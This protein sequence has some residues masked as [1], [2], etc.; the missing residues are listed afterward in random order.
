MPITNNEKSKNIRSW[1]ANIFSAVAVFCVACWGQG[2]FKADSATL[3]IRKL[4]DCFLIPAAILGGV[5][6]MTWISVKGNFYTLSYGTKTFIG[7]IVHPTQKQE[8]FY[9]YKMRQE[10]KNPTGKWAWRTLVVGLVCLAF[11]TIFAIAFEFMI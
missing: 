11:S 6:A 5:G 3:I 7:W 9:E 10:E 4:S 1:I 8:S 2:L